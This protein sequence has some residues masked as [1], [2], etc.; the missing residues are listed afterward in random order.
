MKYKSISILDPAEL[1][2]IQNKSLQLLEEVGIA[3]GDPECR[4]ILVR[5]GAKSV[6]Q[7]DTVRLPREMVLEA[8][9]QLTGA[10]SVYDMHNVPIPLPSVRPLAGSRVRMPRFLEYGAK[11]SRQVCRQDSTNLCQLTAHLSQYKWTV[12]ID[13][14]AS[15]GLPGLDLEETMGRAFAITGHPVFTA[16]TTETGMQR[17]IELASAACESGDVDKTPCTG[18]AVNTT[19]PLQMAGEECRVFRRAVEAGVPIDVEP[20]TVA[21]ATTP[22]TLAGTLVVGNAEVL[23]MLCL[24][25]TI[26]PGA[27]VMESTVGSVMNMKEANL[28]LAAPESMLL[29]SAQAALTRLHGLPTMR[30]G[31]YSD[32]YYLDIQT[33]I[34]KTAFTLMIVL[35]GA[36][37]VLMGGT[38]KD[39]AHNS[40]ESLLIDHDIWELVDRCTTEIVID[41]ERLAYETARTVG[42]GNSYMETDNTIRWMR[43]GEHYYGGSFDRSGRPD[44]TV[45][46]LARAHERVVEILDK[47][48]VYKAPAATVER[49][50]QYLRDRA[51][52]LGIPAADWTLQ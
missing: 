13:T 44:S 21:G 51:R 32:P 26:R 2:K 42:I 33:G 27:K 31:G 11:D 20:M 50:K 8:V 7:S 36:D 38:L 10:F 35:S 52:E 49:I 34:E 12:V 18:V 37:M 43:S 29:A 46:M 14:P 25:N 48:P 3:V 24:A 9:S 41:E 23:Y 15:D 4:D 28:S 22:F 16:P 1:E 17:V 19:S 5:N 47:H 40:Y 6:G 39:A 30:M 45:S